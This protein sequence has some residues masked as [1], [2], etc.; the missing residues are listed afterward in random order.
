[1][2][3]A[4]QTSIFFMYQCATVQSLPGIAFTAKNSRYFSYLFILSS[5]ADPDPHH[6]GK[7]DPDSHK[8]EKVEALVGNFEALEGPILEKSEW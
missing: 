2:W 5:V 7:L 1:M 3:T 4:N 8:T 6:F